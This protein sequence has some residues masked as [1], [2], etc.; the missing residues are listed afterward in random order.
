MNKVKNFIA[1]TQDTYTKR[2]PSNKCRN[3]K[4]VL[5]IRLLVIILFGFAFEM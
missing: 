1:K 3:L 5:V 2:E 4:S